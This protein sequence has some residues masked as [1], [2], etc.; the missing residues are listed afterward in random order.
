KI[1]VPA[2]QTVD[3]DHNEALSD[4]ALTQLPTPTWDGTAWTGAVHL[5]PVDE[6]RHALITPRLIAPHPNLVP[7]SISG[8]EALAMQVLFRDDLERILEPMSLPALAGENDAE[9][10]GLSLD[11]A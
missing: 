4:V 7:D 1:L 8:L 11:D 2:S 10:K 6:V 3:A 9:R 5:A